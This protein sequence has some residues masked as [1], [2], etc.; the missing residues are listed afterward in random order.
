[1]QLLTLSVDLALGMCLA[2]LCVCPGVREEAQTHQT[3]EA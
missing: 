3:E 2:G 1:M